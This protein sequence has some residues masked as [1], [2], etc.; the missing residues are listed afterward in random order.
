M[1]EGESTDPVEV[2]I[3]KSPFEGYA[4][5]SIENARELLQ[6]SGDTL[7][8]G[9]GY[10]LNALGTASHVSGIYPVGSVRTTTEDSRP[11][12]VEDILTFGPPNVRAREDGAFIRGHPGIGLFVPEG[13]EYPNLGR[14]FVRFIFDE[15][16][17]IEL[18]LRE[19]LQ[20]LPLHENMRERSELT[21]A[22]EF[23][24]LGHLLD[25][26][27]AM[28][29]SAVPQDITAQGG[30]NPSANLAYSDGTLGELLAFVIDDGMDPESAIDQVATNLR[31]LLEQTQ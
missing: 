2:T 11:E 17:P 15:L 1:W 26:K 10:V 7:G 9:W 29:D 31:D 21:D 30:F 18:A 4:V 22:E 14:Q 25:V 27:L 13:S 8:W 19:P 12:M 5:E 3:D 16:G 24:G 20:F 28:M 6:Y 23:E